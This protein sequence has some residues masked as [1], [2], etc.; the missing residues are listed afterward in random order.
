MSG[1][2]ARLKVFVFIYPTWISPRWPLRI[3]GMVELAS[4]GVRVWP[5]DYLGPQHTPLETL[6]AWPNAITGMKG[7][8]VEEMVRG[9]GSCLT[10]MCDPSRKTVNFCRRPRGLSCYLREAGVWKQL[11]LLGKLRK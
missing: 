2:M 3:R 8:A 10:E 11:S 5:W 4:A 6:D 1:K 9:T 7:A